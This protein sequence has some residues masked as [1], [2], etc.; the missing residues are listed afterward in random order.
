MITIR[1]VASHANVSVTT[2]SHVINGTRTVSPDAMDRVQKAVIALDYVPSALARSLKSNR[3]HTVGMLIPNNSN[4]YFAEMIRGIEDRCFASGFN[5]VLC[6]TDDDPQKQSV[7]VRVMAEK[8]VDGL[9]VVSSGADPDLIGELRQL[10]MPQ[11]LVDREIDD[12]MADLVEVNHE[13]GAQ[14]ATK[15]LLDL[16]HRRIACIAGPQVVSSARQRLAGYKKALAEA[17]IAFDS[18]L[19]R[20]GDFTS[21]GGYDATLS[22]LT[23][24]GVDATAVFAANDLMAF[25]AI[26]AAAHRGLRIPDDLSIIG[27]DDIALARHTNPPLTTVAQPK[28]ETGHLAADLLMQRIAEPGRALQKRLLQPVLRE[29]ESCAAPAVKGKK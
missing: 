27:F 29:R 16:G 7:Y 23:E 9:I 26:C 22:L 13:S 2:V 8:Q 15:H 10:R 5:V 11:V 14:I 20:E 21:D 4:P 24:E 12:L 6:N 25:G 3:T 19:V 28:H 17:G 18:T 1:D